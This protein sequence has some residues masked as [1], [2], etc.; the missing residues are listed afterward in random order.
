MTGILMLITLAVQAQIK[1][2]T[3]EV[4]D[5]SSS[6]IL[7]ASI[8]I[9]GARTRTSADMDGSFNIKNSGSA[10]LI[11]S[12]IGYE[13]KGLKI[14]EISNGVLRIF[15]K[16]DFKPGYRT[17]NAIWT[18]FN[19]LAKD[20]RSSYFGTFASIENFFTFLVLT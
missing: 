3:G 11:I 8:K 5:L 13:P 4:T 19:Q 14:N 16:K 17:E 18:Y 2:I 7:S 15:T 20:T 12:G 1:G 10:I 9:K 6:P